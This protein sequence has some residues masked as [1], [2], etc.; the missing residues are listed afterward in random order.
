MFAAGPLKKLITIERLPGGKDNN[1]DP[2]SEWVLVTRALANI[3]FLNGKEAL[4][5]SKE[6]STASASIRIRY[7]TDVTADMRI[8]YGGQIFNILAIL[9][10][11]DSREFLDL[12]CEVGANNG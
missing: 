4:M 8:V 1:G 12:A 11:L 6:V 10:N 9:P 7:R 3:R 2:N 5:A